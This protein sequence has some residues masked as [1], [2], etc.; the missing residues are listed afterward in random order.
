MA[1]F[2]RSGSSVTATAAAAAVSVDARAQAVDDYT[3]STQEVAQP[4]G[5][6]YRWMDALP[7]LSSDALQV[8]RDMHDNFSALAEAPAYVPLDTHLNAVCTL[9]RLLNTLDKQEDPRVLLEPVFQHMGQRCNHPY[10]ELYHRVVYAAERWLWSVQRDDVGPPDLNHTISPERRVA[11]VEQCKLLVALMN[12]VQ[13]CVVRGWVSRPSGLNVNIDY[14]QRLQVLVRSYGLWSGAVVCLGSGVPDA[15]PGK[16]NGI[17]LAQLVTTMRM[18]NEA[19]RG[20]RNLPA[21]IEVAQRLFHL[22]NPLFVEAHADDTIEM[23]Y[24]VPEQPATNRPV[25]TTRL[26]T[27]SLYVLFLRCAAAFWSYSHMN[28]AVRVAAELVL[29]W[30]EPVPSLANWCAQQRTVHKTALPSWADIDELLRKDIPLFPE[31]MVHGNTDAV[32]AP[33]PLF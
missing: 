22:P 8:L 7:Q 12:H 16:P 27:E 25:R 19:M 24:T 23:P 1:W 2:A 6:N 14:L 17:E 11:Q 18:L 26:W 20:L 4:E 13:R 33:F 29:T 31:A 21:R 5:N 28:R 30:H 15:E 3:R 10:F 9:A 32:V